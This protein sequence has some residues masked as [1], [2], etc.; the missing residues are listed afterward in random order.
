MKKQKKNKQVEVAPEW[1]AGLSQ[2]LEFPSL[3]DYAVNEGIH[4]EKDHFIIQTGLGALKYGRTIFIKPSGYPRS[5]R[6]GW[7]DSLFHS[8]DADISVHIEPFH[9]TI[10][11]KKLKDKLD[12]LE[13]VYYS[14]VK[15]ENHA[16]VE[17]SQQ[18]IAD[19]KRL[20]YQIRNNTNGLYFA[21]VQ[22]TV[23]ADTLEELNAKC[24]NIETSLGGESIEL[25]NA[26][27]RQK[28]G[29]LSTLPLGRNALSNSARNLDQLALTAMFPHSSSRL[30]HNGGIPIGIYGREYVYFNQFDKKLNNYNLGIFGE[31]GSGK[32][33]FVKQIIGRGFSDG[34]SRC[35]IVDV[36]PEYT[37]L[38][39]AL[40]GIVIELRTDTTK[41]V[42]SRI[43]PLDIYVE[44][45]IVNK[46]TKN[47]YEVE[48]INLNEK[49]KEVIEFFK[50][51]KETTSGTNGITLTPVELGILND[52]IEELYK[53]RG[54]TEDPE[55]IYEQI[56]TIDESG[57][58]QFTRKYIDMPTITDVYNKLLSTL[59]EYPELKDMV[60]IVKLFTKGKAFGMFDGQTE[61]ISTADNVDLDTAPIVTF[62]ISRLS[63][64]GIDRPIAQHV[65]MSWIWNRFVKN[66][67][68]AMKR[69]IQ[70]EA[71]MTLQYSSM[72]EFFKLLSARGR[73]WNVSLTLVSQRYSMF[74]RTP[75][76]SDI[77][78]QLASVA[79]L[80]Q[81][82]QDIDPIL[83]TFRFSD[84]VGQRIRTSEIGDVLLKAGKEIVYFKS[85]PTPDEWVYLN[86]NQN[87]KTE[88]LL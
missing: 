38:T 35:C 61:I 76:A 57:K 5:V 68:K 11:T 42:S 25:I 14:A 44:K 78:A 65:L 71:W 52:I 34:I 70:D 37:E 75:A 9:R 62:D 31:S 12:K 43:N 85:S 27:G 23:Y 51:M 80:K 10:A 6:V 88:D 32:S 66:D 79:F 50:V 15:N 24:V 77:V 22:A 26:F 21:A 8:D 2:E 28:E 60:N 69:V 72:V 55:S 20:Q 67:P 64:K 29:W 49:V 4:F 84:E 87:I 16:R 58:V 3:V 46:N 63:E 36:E 82:D 45:D 86:T 30:N 54:V 73:K 56:E 1:D 18:K 7:L 39:H 48:K 40:G 83:D 47:E 33:V 13:A 19:T 59:E 74:H 53:E 41:G 81:S 17:E